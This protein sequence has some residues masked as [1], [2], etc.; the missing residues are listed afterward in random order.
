MSRTQ[1]ACPDCGHIGASSGPCKCSACGYKVLM[2]PC[3]NRVING[4]WLEYYA[5]PSTRVPVPKYP[6]LSTY[7]GDKNG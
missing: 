1:V 4:N 3:Y 5:R 6:E 7:L 2:L